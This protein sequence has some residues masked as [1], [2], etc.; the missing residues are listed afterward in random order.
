MDSS[1]SPSKSFL[2]GQQYALFVL[3]KK[4][5]GNSFFYSEILSFYL[6]KLRVLE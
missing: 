1:S 4:K 5:N 2:V 3:K 6:N